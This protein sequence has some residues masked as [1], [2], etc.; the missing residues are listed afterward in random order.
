MMRGD[1]PAAHTVV[2][3][4]A[5]TALVYPGAEALA[6]AA[7]CVLPAA[8]PQAH[9]LATWVCTQ[10]ESSEGTKGTSSG[11]TNVPLLGLTPVGVA[12]QLKKPPDCQVYPL[13]LDQRCSLFFHTAL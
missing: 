9:T 12:S 8:A 3:L 7:V 4:A 13:C 1:Q 2:Q 5:Q 6:I 11:R 10:V